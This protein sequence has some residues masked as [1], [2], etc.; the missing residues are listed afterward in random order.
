[1]NKSCFLQLIFTLLFTLLKA[2]FGAG[3]LHVKITPPVLTSSADTIVIVL[4]DILTSTVL[5]VGI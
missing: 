4:E 1:M 2:T 5:L 3:T